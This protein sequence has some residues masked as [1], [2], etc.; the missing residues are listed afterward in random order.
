M[1]ETKEQ[2]DSEIIDFGFDV[3]EADVARP[4]LKTATLDAEIAFV[5]QVETQEKKLKQILV[6]YR[7][8]EP[9]TAID[10]KLIN[11]GFIIT[12]RILNEPT[13]GYTEEM[14]QDNLKRV[15]F[16]A[17]GP[18][19]VNT[20]AWLDKPVRIRVTFRDEHTDKNGV[21]RPASNDVTGVYPMPKA[22]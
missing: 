2:P 19:K 17:A 16:A 21:D 14:R 9:A 15:H 13:G 8:K 4:L 20:K 18:G 1:E 22:A 5:R 11:P 7:L 10:G 12:Q 3:T 6:G